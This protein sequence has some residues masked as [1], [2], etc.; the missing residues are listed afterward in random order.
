MCIFYW[1]SFC[2]R[3]GISS[4][5]NGALYIIKHVFLLFCIQIMLSLK[6]LIVCLTCVDSNYAFTEICHTYADEYF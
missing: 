3:F 6:S 2:C 1:I 5:E 4:F